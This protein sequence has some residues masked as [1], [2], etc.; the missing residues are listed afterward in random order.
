MTHPWVMDNNCVKYYPD[1]ASGY[2]VMAG[3]DV[4]SQTDRQ[5]D[6]TIPIYMYPPNPPHP[7]SLCQLHRSVGHD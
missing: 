3:H 2:E 1:R 5:M 7:N 4:N 6:R